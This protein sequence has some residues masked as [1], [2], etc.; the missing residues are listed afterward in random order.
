MRYIKKL[1]GISHYSPGNGSYCQQYHLNRKQQQSEPQ[2]MQCL[3][4]PAQGHTPTFTAPCTRTHTHMLEVNC[5]H[6]C[7]ENRTLQTP[8]PHVGDVALSATFSFI[9]N[10]LSRVILAQLSSS[11]GVGT[12]SGIV[13]ATLLRVSNLIMASQRARLGPGPTFCPPRT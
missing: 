3:L 7:M 13:M 12:R 1:S 11:R 4:L 6:V 8:N 10:F 9:R 5:L 2:C